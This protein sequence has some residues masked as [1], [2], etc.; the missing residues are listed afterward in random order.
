MH[1]ILTSPA[2]SE[3]HPSFMPWNQA[4]EKGDKRAHTPVPETQHQ[5]Q[6][7][8]DPRNPPPPPPPLDLWSEIGPF[9]ADAYPLARAQLGSERVNWIQWLS[10]QQKPVPQQQLGGGHWKTAKKSR[11]KQAG[12]RPYY[13]AESM[14]L[15]KASALIWNSSSESEE[16]ES[17]DIWSLSFEDR[18]RIAVGWTVQLRQR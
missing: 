18:M 9:L 14:L 12:V 15:A 11:K 17:A 6:Q 4:S 16:L 10:G 8:G 3:L 5:Q 2:G 13:E 1:L 7:R